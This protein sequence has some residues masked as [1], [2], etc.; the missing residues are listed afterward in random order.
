MVASRDLD[1]TRVVFTGKDGPPG[2]KTLSKMIEDYY[3]SPD[4]SPVTSPARPP[5]NKSVDNS[6]KSTTHNSVFTLSSASASNNTKNEAKASFSRFSTTTSSSSGD[7][8]NGG[9]T[10]NTLEST[11]CQNCSVMSAQISRLEKALHQN[12]EGKY[13]IAVGPGK[14]L[15]LLADGIEVTPTEETRPSSPTAPFYRP[16]LAGSRL[17]PLE[18]QS[19]EEEEADAIERVRISRIRSMRGLD[20]Y[21]HGGNEAVNNDD[22][23]DDDIL[24]LN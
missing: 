7:N 8:E 12:S 17:M 9:A 21:L 14:R 18:V 1:E 24:V 10:N 16:P 2:V 5:K 15:R 22:E 3:N 23:D 13:Q 19:D 11:N 20:A 6:N 4:T